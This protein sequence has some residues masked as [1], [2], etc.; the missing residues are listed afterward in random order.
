MVTFASFKELRHSRIFWYGFAVGFT[1]NLGF[2]AFLIS[3][4]FQLNSTLPDNITNVVN[5]DRPNTLTI[6]AQD[7]TILAQFGDIAYDRKT[8]TEIPEKLQQAFIA[9]EDSR[10][11]KHNGVDI[12]G[13]ARASVANLQSG[14][15]KEG[16]STITQQLAR[17]AY[18]DQDRSWER[19]LKEVIIAQKID[20]Q[21]SKEEILQTYLNVVYLGSGAYGVADA[22]HRY[23]SKSLD[24][25]TLGEIAT[26]AG[27]TPAP[28]IYSPLENPESAT[29]RRNL[30]LTRM[31]EQGYITPEEAQIAIET[32]LEIKSSP[33]KRQIKKAP[34]FVDYV[35]KEMGKYV[36]RDKLA[37]GGIIVNTTLNPQWQETGEEIVENVIKRYGKWQK[38]QQGAL[39]AID[40]RNGEIL[41]MVGGIDFANNQYNRVTQA[42]RQPGSTFKTFIYA[43]A[44]AGGMSPYK[45]YLDAPYVVDGYEPK[46]YG[47]SYRGDVS[48]SQALTS[49]LNTVAVKSLI[50]VGWNPVIKVAEKMGIESKLQPTYSLAL[51]ASEVNLLELTS[52]YGTLANQGQHLQVH[53][54]KSIVNADGEILYQAKINPQTALDK[55]SANIMTWMLQ[56]VVQSGT[57]IPAQIGR[58]VAGKTGTSDKARDLWFIGY[59]PQLATG[60]WVGND[61]N[62]E[63]WG[64]S[65]ITAQMWRNFM[66]KATE[67]MPVETFGKPPGK[68]ALDKATIKLEPLKPR[69]SYHKVTIQQYT[70]NNDP[71]REY[72]R[73]RRRRR[74]YDV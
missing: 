7:N 52:A 69:Q 23:F 39:V 47:D 32:P 41:T 71:P 33:L 24:E 8:I 15:V 57:G 31:A 36:S 58:P 19:K 35:Q 70:Q 74:N 51:G 13:I 17:I 22:A 6:K 44:I 62:K 26:L 45:N 29:T 54:I 48:I 27:I 49:S 59:I 72:R 3:K 20:H 64:S 53:G 18:L 14:K 73:R 4:W 66:L 5:Y 65:A 1:I 12:Q 16:G 40:P 56:Q 30:V 46:N 43:T 10:Y 42:Q 11:Y 9:I 63:T 38:F 68:L 21:I 2:L 50:D 67:K 37:E 55:D 60:I 34:Y 28:S 61:D 25:L